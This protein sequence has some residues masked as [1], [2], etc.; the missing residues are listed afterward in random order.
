MFP[1]FHLSHI[2]MCTCVCVCAP[3]PV[4]RQLVQRL[5]RQRHPPQLPVSLSAVVS[6]TIRR[7]RNRSQA[8]YE[9]HSGRW[10]SL[11]NKNETVRRRG[12]TCRCE[13][14]N[15]RRPAGAGA[16]GIT[17]RS[18]P[19]RH[20]AVHLADARDRSADRTRT[21]TAPRSAIGDGASTRRAETR[22]RRVV[23]AM[24][25][26]AAPRQRSRRRAPTQLTLVGTTRDMY[27][28]DRHP[29]I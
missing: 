8:I 18:T 12:D 11:S 17:A 3:S 24:L 22:T 9:A 2:C 20:R 5:G 27:C 16:G 4:Q 6:R 23:S 25:H 29:L 10:R 21:R 7:R 15:L 26:R 14:A 1:L 13:E 19:H 28:T